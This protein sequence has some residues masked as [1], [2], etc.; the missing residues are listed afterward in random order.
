M[1]YKHKNQFRCQIVRGKAL[2]D[3]D[4]LLAAYAQIICD[5]CPLYA[6]DFKLEFNK[7]IAH[8]LNIS[9]KKT[10]DNHRTETAGK[11]FGMYFED[12]NGVVYPSSRT[13]KLQ[14]RPKFHNILT[15]LFLP[16]GVILNLTSLSSTITVIG[17]KND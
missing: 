5:I 13:L 9:S 3:L 4:N 11:L 12:K 8:Y 15:K 1:T 16:I 7:R 2:S 10:I 6:S 17:K 14:K